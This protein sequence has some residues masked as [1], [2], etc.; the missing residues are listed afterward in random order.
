MVRFIELRRVHFFR[1][2]TFTFLLL[3]SIVLYDYI[4]HVKQ[5]KLIIYSVRN[6]FYLDVFYGNSCY[7][8]IKEKDYESELDVEYNILPNRRYHLI[9]DVKSME[10]LSNYS[11]LAQSELLVLGKRS[12]LFLGGPLMISDLESKINVDYLVVGKSGLPYLENTLNSV[13]L[14]TLILDGTLNAYERQKS[15][16]LSAQSFPIH[17]LKQDGAFVIAI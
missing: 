9:S 2:F 12:I 17:D 14:K 5:E 15:R 8:N 7:S 13:E 11:S 6:Q 3:T 1:N 10:K 16:K 4:S